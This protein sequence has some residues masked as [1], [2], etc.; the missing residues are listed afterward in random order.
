MRHNFD[1]IIDRRNSDCKKYEKANYP[2]DIIPM[3][4]ADTDFAAPKEI[5]DAI[6]ERAEH[7]CYGYPVETFEFEKAV[8]RWEKVRFNWDCLLYTSD[9]ADE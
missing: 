4:I 8:A 7:A 5:V 2:E 3:W 1:E 6:K 9:A